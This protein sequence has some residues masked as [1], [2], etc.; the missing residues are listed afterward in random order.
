[1]RVTLTL[2]ERLKREVQAAADDSHRSISGEISHRL[3]ASLKLPSTTL[4]SAESQAPGN[5]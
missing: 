5:T 3:E 1:M 4:P 2:P